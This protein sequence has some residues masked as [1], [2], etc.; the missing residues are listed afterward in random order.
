MPDIDSGAT[1]WVLTSSAL[2]FLMTPALALFFGGFVGTRMVTNTM[3]MSFAAL[4]IVTIEWSLIGYSMAFAPNPVASLDPYIGGVSFG[5]FDSNDRVRINTQIPEHA[6]FVFQLAFAVV[7][8]AVISGSV[9]GRINFSAWCIFAGAWHL[10]V[11]APLA[12]WV[13]HPS[14]FLA[15]RG[16]QDF[17]GG[18]VVEYNCGISGIT[19]AFLVG[20]AERAKAKKHEEDLENERKKGLINGAPG[21]LDEDTPEASAWSGGAYGPRALR[22]P[23]N[24]P[25]VLLGTGLLFFGWVGFNSGSALT[26]GHLASRAFANTCLS[27]AAGVF[28]AGV[29]EALAEPCRPRGKRCS[30]GLSASGAATG[31]IVSLAAITPACG[32][33]SQMASLCLGFFSSFA[34]ARLES[35]LQTRG[36]TLVDDTLSGFT[37]HG[38]GGLLGT[39]FVGF[40][41]STREGAPVNGLF[42]GGSGNL[43]GIQFAGLAATTCLAVIGTALSWGIALAILNS[44][45]EEVLVPKDIAGNL[46]SAMHGQSAYEFRAR[47]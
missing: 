26:A 28:G 12:R 24:V 43:L 45:G 41:S 25:F 39:L 40:A 31:M 3:L 14:G 1:A 18:L 11:Y 15:A 23:H 27:A 10:I 33:I 8:C 20:L 30:S 29:A 36:A 5:A 16:I 13:F 47:E 35:L 34:A 4:V 7:T 46:D 19:L 42:Y 17:A 21:G 37:G 44:I 22:T 9:V 38:V 6:Y 32:Y 2:V